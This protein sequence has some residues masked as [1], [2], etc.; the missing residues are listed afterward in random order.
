MNKHRK[1]AEELVSKMTLE[2][3]VSQTLYDAPAI[4]RLGIPAYNWWN[5]SLHGVARA[6]TATVFPQA[7]GMAATFDAD[8]IEQVGKA[9]AQEGRAKYNEAQKHGEHGIYKGLTFWAPNVNI[10]RDPRWGRGQETYGEDPYLTSLLAVTFINALQEEVDGNLMAAACA[11]HFAVHSGPEP[12][13]HSFNAEVSDEDLYNTYLPAF[14]ASVKKAHVESVMGAYNAVNGTPSCMNKRLLMD[15]LRDKWH[16]EGHVV[17]DCGAIKDL[18][19]GHKVS[20]SPYESAVLA[21]NNGCD[22]N[23]GNEY[24][25]LTEAV[26]NGD[27]SEKTIDDAVIRLMEL[28]FKLGILGEKNEKLEQISYEVV[29]D[30]EKKNL[31]EEVA[32][33]SVVLLK[34]ENNILPL[35]KNKIHSIGVIG[36]NANSRKALVGNYE[37]TASRYIT[38]LEG[39]QDYVGRDVTVRYSQGCHLY[40]TRKNASLSKA[41]DRIAEARSICE[42]SD[43]IILVLGLDASIEGEAG[44]AGNDFASGDKPDLF[45]PGM[46]TELMETVCSYGKPVILISMSGSAMDLRYAQDHCRAILQAWYPGARGGKA[47]AE[48]L[49]GSRCPEGKLPVTV[50]NKVQDLPDIRD[51]SM[52]SRTY[53]YMSSMPLYPFGYGLS[54][55]RY[56]LKNVDLKVDDTAE[57]SFCG[58]IENEGIYDSAETVQVYVKAPGSPVPNPQLKALYKI[59]L[60]A[61]ETVHIECTIPKE[62]FKIYD[63]DG[64]LVINN[65]VFDVY[66]GLNQPDMRSFELTGQ[67]VY[68]FSVSS[69]SL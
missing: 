39:I 5:E 31:N 40:K 42:M 12:E 8:L 50:Y 21:I 13:R 11:K 3:K 68:R 34:N 22:L 2:E 7:I 55:N 19:R 33:K 66:I 47:I 17:S 49:F 18:H 30:N 1:M 35:D 25:R 61:K 44:D 38:V 24:S 10:F 23:C 69:D 53:R 60:K 37:G 32:A 29:D 48:I 15:I 64:E 6:G 43:I 27:V 36:P 56:K 26:C 46:Q 58:D 62:A 9:I 67:D 16:F 63:K 65:G 14:E 28:R 4:P 57:V 54:Y 52:K 59:K 51:Y 20:K 45:F 41:T